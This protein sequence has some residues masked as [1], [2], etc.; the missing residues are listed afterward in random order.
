MAP[1]FFAE[2]ISRCVMSST[3]ARSRLPHGAAFHTV[4]RITAGCL[5]GRGRV[6]AHAF[7]VGEDIRCVGKLFN[8]SQHQ[9]APLEPLHHQRSQRG[10]RVIDNDRRRRLAFN[11]D[12]R[13]ETR[14]SFRARAESTKRASMPRPGG[15]QKGAT[16]SPQSIQLFPAA[17]QV[18]C[19]CDPFEAQHA[20]FRTLSDWVLLNARNIRR[21]Y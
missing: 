9:Q 21:V 18:A 4:P 19:V 1:E 6:F 3:S 11:G 5:S 13:S 7:S 15:K 16:G 10:E 17:P 12:G 2:H 14:L 20:A 8:N